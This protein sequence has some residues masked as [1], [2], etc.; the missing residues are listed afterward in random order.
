MINKQTAGPSA[1]YQLAPQ[2]GAA[3]TVSKGQI[4]R[5][6]DVDGQQVADLVCFA[7]HNIEEYLSS[8]RTIDYNE[9]IFLSTGDT[10]YSNCSNPML[11]ILDDP[12]AK[13]D[14][15]FA[16]CSQEMFNLNY[17]TR[18]PHPNCLDNLSVSLRPWGIKASQIP[19]AFNI[20]MNVAITADGNVTVHPPLSKAGDYID[21]QTRMN[22]IVGVTACSA[23]KCNNYKCTSIRIEVY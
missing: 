5:I 19:T 20:F 16:P 18:D 21:L 23:A 12:V 11:R 7:Q 22:L 9:K 13:H 6:I 4:I 3:F 10:L 1:R 15:L 2:T 14:F 8:G 17:G